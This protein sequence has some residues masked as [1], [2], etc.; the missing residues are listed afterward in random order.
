ML[1]KNKRRSKKDKTGRNYICGCGKNYLSYPALYTHIKNK[2]E[3]KAPEGTTLQPATRVK[4]GRP[5]KRADSPSKKSDHDG[6]ENEDDGE[7]TAKSSERK[8]MSQN[9]FT[10]IKTQDDKIKY[11]ILRKE[12]LSIEDLELV[13]ELKCEG[14]ASP[15]QPFVKGRNPITNQL[16][17]HPIA[18]L[19]SCLA[20][21]ATDDQ[22]FTQLNCD[23][24]FAIFLYNLSKFS[25]QSFYSMASLVIRGLR[26]CLKEHGYELLQ[27][28]EAQNPSQKIELFKESTDT[29]DD[30]SFCNVEPAWYIT[31][32]FDFFV[33]EYFPMYLGGENFNLGFVTSFLQAFNDWLINNNLS[34]IKC[35]FF[36]YY[37]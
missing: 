30:I 26:Q 22:F 35:E 20:H 5:P 13:R 9:D 6:S 37:K 14:K 12:M 32:I 8:S 24:I 18:E 21:D 34:K 29:N 17:L 16:I 33:K 2:H 3:G 7:Q 4:P 10:P 25:N 1:Q 31:I 19:L 27:L 23:K 36:S 11:S 15:T 28:F